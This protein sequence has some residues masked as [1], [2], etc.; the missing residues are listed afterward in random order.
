MTTIQDILN[1]LIS[2]ENHLEHFGKKGM[3]WGKRSASTSSGGPKLR[4]RERSK[5]IQ[6]ARI[7]TAIN[8]RKAQMLE[9]RAIV[10]RTSKEAK[11]FQNKA[12][13]QYSKIEKTSD[14]QLAQKSTRGEK[15]AS[16]LLLGTVGL[17][18]VSM[19]GSSSPRKYL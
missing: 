16:G 10:S 5:A 12:D 18:L 9:D 6:K 3:R 1:N 7:N 4:G 11:Y 14:Y 13:R 8:S 2:K 19:I 17:S 15:I